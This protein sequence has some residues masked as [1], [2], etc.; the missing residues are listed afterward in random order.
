MA[1]KF[2][3]YYAGYVDLGKKIGHKLVSLEPDKYKEDLLFV[4]KSVPHIIG[5]HVAINLADGRF[6]RTTLDNEM[7]SEEHIKDLRI[8]SNLNYDKYSTRKARERVKRTDNS[9]DNYTLAEL[10][11]WC[12]KSW[13]RKEQ[14]LQ[15]L[16]H[17]LRL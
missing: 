16:R 7:E 11:E 15:Y 9:L 12:G 14:M 6:F 3:A 17:K 4:S 10:R 13:Q 5:Q 2:K 8:Q 1:T